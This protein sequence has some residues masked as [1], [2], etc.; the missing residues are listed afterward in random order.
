MRLAEPLVI[1][2]IVVGGIAVAVVDFRPALLL[3]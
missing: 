2:R 3:N 1:G